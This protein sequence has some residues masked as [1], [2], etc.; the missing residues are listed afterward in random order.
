MQS[1][2]LQYHSSKIHYRCGGHGPQSLVCFHGYGETGASFDFLEN[3]LSASHK[4]IAIDLPFHGSTEWKEPLLNARVLAD[5]IK[6]LLAHLNT[7][8]KNLQLMGFS[9]GGRMALCVL[10]QMPAQVSKLVLLAPDG[11][12][13][14]FWYW[15]S[16]QTAPGN[17]LF[18]FTM[19]KPGWFLGMLRLSNKLRIINQ[20]I[21]KFIEYYIHDEAV[22]K[23]LY[24]RWTGMSKCTPSMK[25][26]RSLISRHQVAVRLLYGKYDRIISHKRGS[27]LFSDAPNCTVRVLSCGHQVLHEKNAEAIC[28]ALSS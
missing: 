13:V 11:L 28:N 16:T 19:R 12:T 25:R 21:Y 24:E 1:G 27:K 23:E 7:E 26:V 5:V 2:F 22:R 4:I 17:S 15:L 14:N 10:E 6:A 9:M 3:H 18:K 8:I 20:S